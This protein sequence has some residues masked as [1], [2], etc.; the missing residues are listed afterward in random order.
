MVHQ[1][2]GDGGVKARRVVARRIFI[3][4]PARERF[5]VS[6]EEMQHVSE[7]APWI[8]A[9]RALES[10]RSD[11]LFHDPLAARLAGERG[12][13]IARSLPD[14][15]WVVAIR[16]VVID[17]FLLSAISSGV[18]TIVN[19]GAGLDTRPYRMDLPASIRWVE[20]DYPSLIEGKAAQL[21]NEVPACSVE[22][23]GLDLAD[24]GSRQELFERITATSARTMAL[25]EG[26]IGYLSVGEAGALADDLHAQSSCHVWVTEYFSSRLLRHHQT[27][28]S[29]SGIPVRF[30]PADWEAFFTEHRWSLGEIRYLG[31]E[32]RRLNRPV[33]LT[34]FERGT[35]AFRSQAKRRQMLRDMGYAVLERAS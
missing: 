34:L 2:M 3:A 27:H 16:T 19:V 29:R 31:E 5:K 33:P 23:F 6:D 13:K 35:R 1:L 12:F 22:R 8:A 25:T 21:S 26:L 24:R 20:I 11:A 9:C 10:N 14:G 4:A 18:D 17:A 28:Q 7:T 32:S 15:L 30:H